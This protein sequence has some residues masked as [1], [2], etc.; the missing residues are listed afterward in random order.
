MVK[1]ES[2]Q[3]LRHHWNCRWAKIL[4]VAA[5]YNFNSL[6][7][8]DY[9]RAR[10]G[11]WSNCVQFSEKRQNMTLEIHLENIG[12]ASAFGIKDKVVYYMISIVI[13]LSLL[14]GFG[15]E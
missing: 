6:P 9:F 3:V 5:L 2:K 15:E 4:S 1:I 12:G 8:I 10:V 11:L 14:L 7:A 13:L